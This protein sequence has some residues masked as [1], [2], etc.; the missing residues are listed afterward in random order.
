[1]EPEPQKE[2]TGLERREIAPDP[3][4]R[5]VPRQSLAENRSRGAAY[6]P[7]P[8]FAEEEQKPAP[9]NGWKRW[10]IISV[11]ALFLG[12]SAVEIPHWLAPPKQSDFVLTSADIDQVATG[13]AR[14]A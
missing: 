12:F 1:M 10:A 13:S 5:A 9:K 11:A 14:E 3:K 7:K 4:K 6:L 8:E 2:Q